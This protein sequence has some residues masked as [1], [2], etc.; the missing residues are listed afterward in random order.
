MQSFRG[1]M[2]KWS[3]KGKV[4]KKQAGKGQDKKKDSPSQPGGD[5]GTGAGSRAQA[6]ASNSEQSGGIGDAELKGAIAMLLVQHDQMLRELNSFS[7]DKVRFDAETILG[8]DYK[9][10]GQNYHAEVQAEGFDEE[11]GPVSLRLF[12]RTVE[13]MMQ[14]GTEDQKEQAKKFYHKMNGEAENGED[15]Q[16]MEQHSTEEMLQICQHFRVQK[17]W[18]QKEAKQ[19]II[20]QFRVSDK[21]LSQA[22]LSFLNDQEGAKRLVGTAPPGPIVRKLQKY[23][24]HKVSGR[25][26]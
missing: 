21:K 11:R 15:D 1:A 26:K 13:E 2:A 14:S 5:T 10:I 24:D 20:V 23:I 19:N 8:N 9:T 17:C 6:K 4:D 18:K 16:D 3:M 22:L 7:Y 12:V 25:K